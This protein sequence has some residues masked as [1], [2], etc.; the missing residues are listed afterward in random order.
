MTK[1]AGCV[2]FERNQITARMQGI[3]VA[4]LAGPM[5]VNTRDRHQHQS[6]IFLLSRRWLRFTTHARRETM[7]TSTGRRVAEFVR[8][9]VAN[10]P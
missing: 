6:L 2:Y 1:R 10:Q 9:A 3:L 5:L 8:G 7:L 4:H